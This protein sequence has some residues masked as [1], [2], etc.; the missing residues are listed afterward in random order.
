MSL[1]QFASAH[2]QA[3]F[4][5]VQKQAHGVPLNQLKTSLCV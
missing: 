5:S 2:Q 1:Q 3:I 4:A